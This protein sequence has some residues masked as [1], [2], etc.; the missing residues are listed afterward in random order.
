MNF[1]NCKSTTKSIVKKF[2]LVLRN[3]SLYG[4]VTA[5]KF[6]R[7]LDQHSGNMAQHIEFFLIY[8]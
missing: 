8:N 3:Q 6:S 5:T 4:L 2:V 7:V 1:T